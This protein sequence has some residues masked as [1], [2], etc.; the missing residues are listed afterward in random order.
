MKGAAA[1]YFSCSSVAV[2]NAFRKQEHS[3]GHSKAVF[4]Q[5]TQM[6]APTLEKV[7]IPDPISDPDFNR[8]ACDLGRQVPLISC[9]AC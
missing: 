1:Y 4:A 9:I 8:P 2:L 6:A 5:I 7:Y 3:D